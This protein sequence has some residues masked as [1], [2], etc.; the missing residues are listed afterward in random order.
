MEHWKDK[1]AI[2][3][4]ASAGIGKAVAAKLTEE[5]MRVAAV[6]R[7]KERLQELVN[8]YKGRIYAFPC[9]I[10]Q[11]EELV[12]LFKTIEETIGPCHVLVNNAGTAFKSDVLECNLKEWRYMFDLNVIAV[13]VATREAISSMKRNKIDDGQ[14]INI[15]SIASKG[16]PGPEGIGRHVYNATKHALRVLTEGARME[17]AQQKSGIKVSTICPGVVETEIFEVGGWGDIFLNDQTPA[18]QPNAIADG[19]VTLLSTPHSTHIADLV[20]RPLGEKLYS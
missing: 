12:K 6:A 13:G 3:T 9:D 19:V 18:L 7:R 5:G 1:V 11:D 4:G 16:I 2:V 20:I 10:T 15:S 8:Q 14:V 17:L